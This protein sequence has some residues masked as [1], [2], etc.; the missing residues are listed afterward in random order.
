MKR[1]TGGVYYRYNPVLLPTVKFKVP[2]DTR[3]TYSR[4]EGRG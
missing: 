3:T 2:E 1:H 4:A